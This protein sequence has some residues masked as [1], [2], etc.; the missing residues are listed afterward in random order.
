MLW[1]RLQG[2]RN[3]TSESV[4]LFGLVYILFFLNSNRKLLSKK[5]KQNFDLKKEF[6]NR[7]IET[8]L[9]GYVTRDSEITLK[10]FWTE[11]KNLQYAVHSNIVHTD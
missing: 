7:K 1:R 9:L 5:W 3:A 4:Q 11:D 2:Q 10:L 8:G 6:P